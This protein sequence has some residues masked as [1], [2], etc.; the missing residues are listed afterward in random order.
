MLIAERLDGL[1]RWIEKIDAFH[2]FHSLYPSILAALDTI[3]KNPKKWTPDAVTGAESQL[4][5]IKSF[6]FLLSLEVVRDI[7]GVC[8][9]I[10]CPYAREKNRPLQNIHACQF[11]EISTNQV[12]S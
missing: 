6:R 10:N 9:T 5:P 11:G 8:K 3:I 2:V 12:K 4:G 7:L 1:K